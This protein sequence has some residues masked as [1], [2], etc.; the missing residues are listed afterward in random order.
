LLSILPALPPNALENF[1]FFFGVPHLFF[2]CPPRPDVFSCVSFLSKISPQAFTTLFPPP[3]S[4]QLIGPFLFVVFLPLDKRSPSPLSP[5]PPRGGKALPLMKVDW[6]PPP[7]FGVT[8]YSLSFLFP[9]S[10]FLEDPFPFS[11]RSPP[12]PSVSRLRF[13]PCASAGNRHRLPRQRQQPKSSLPS[14]PHDLPK[15]FFFF[16]FLPDSNHSE[17]LSPPKPS[18]AGDITGDRYPLT[19]RSPTFLPFFFLHDPRTLPL[20]KF[21]IN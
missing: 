8:V 5:K 13:L 19:R 17:D 1:F 3:L 21:L 6:N 15:P 9:F 14:P 20:L 11:S 16:D 4:L 7:F 10:I 12:P 18:L 2:L